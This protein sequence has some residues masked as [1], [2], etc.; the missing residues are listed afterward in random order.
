MSQAAIISHKID[1]IIAQRK[2][3]AVD[4]KKKRDA[5]KEIKTVLDSNIALA[6]IVSDIDDEEIRNKCIDMLNKMS[7]PMELVNSLNGIIRL[8]DSAV[9]RFERD[10]INIATV[11]RA[12]QGK[13]M[14]LQS[15]SDLGNDI[16]PA[17]DAGDCTGT[18]SIIH[19]DQNIEEGQVRVKLT[20]RSADDIVSIVNNYL[21][22]I[23]PTYRSMNTITFDNIECIPVDMLG[24]RIKNGNVKASTALKHLRKIVYAFKGTI[25]VTGSIKAL[26][27]HSEMTLTDPN[28]IKT[29]V[30]Q[31]NGIGE[32]KPGREE[33]YNYFAISKAEIHCK[34]KT[35]VGKLILI[36][37][38]G[39]GDTQ[40]GIEESMIETVGNKCDAAIVMRMPDSG[41]HEEDLKLYQLLE[42]E[43][44]NRDLSKWLFYVANL[45]KGRNDDSVATYYNDVKN[46]NFRIAGC[47]MLDCS[48]KDQVKNDF[49]ISTLNTL[50]SN[51][52]I[53]DRDYLNEID[54]KFKEFKE[55][56]LKFVNGLSEA[57]GSN[58]I[59]SIATF[60][61]GR[62]CYRNLTSDLSQQVTELY[63][64]KSKPNATMWN[65]V[66][67]IL[68]NLENV[69]PSEEVVQKVIE[70]SGTLMGYDIWT[71]PLNYVRN[72]ITDQFIE[73]DKPMEK[74]TLDFKNKLVKNLYETLK[75]L[76]GENIEQPDQNYAR[77]LWEVIA[78]LIKDEP[79][80]TQIY[81]ALQFINQFEFN[82]RAELIRE[83]RNQLSIINPMTPDC[84]MQPAY[85]FSKVQA[86]REIKF[87]MSSRIAIIEDGL[88]HSLSK[89]NR[90]P[91]EAFYAAAEEFYD[92]LTF[93]SNLDDGNFIDMSDVWGRFFTQYGPQLFAKTLEKYKKMKNFL[94]EYEKFRNKLLELI[95]SI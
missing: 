6:A 4:I 31:N 95:N 79:D 57:G 67:Y 75:T 66:R 88:R 23:D 60:D 68:D 69:L 2:L 54:A 24:L 8:Y 85:N 94:E 45:Y 71:V 38:I 16:I 40:Y 84:Y 86:G 51:M 62:E 9:S 27:G 90:L 76:A 80:Y 73:I 74:E 87:F 13:S 19:N 59:A 1:E 93:S 78:P 21:N 30:A 64:K 32:D 22:E 63:R 43:F 11:G 41:V 44:A 26:F 28:V 91:N 56:I 47:T 15:V 46:G 7:I 65:K 12:R 81:K 52:D 55:K 33:Y 82:V 29:Y 3:K 70:K 18:V 39:V 89:L 17:Y 10:S 48:D 50:T 58:D 14:F 77:W 34:F 49:L 25:G 36:D 83:V 37:T 42:E 20:F 53:I 5:L 61:K 35:D 72:K 92:R